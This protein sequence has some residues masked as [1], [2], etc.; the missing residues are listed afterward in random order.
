[1]EEV[2]GVRPVDSRQ[3]YRC[4]HPDPVLRHLQLHFEV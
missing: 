1:M 2:K 3:Q 4:I